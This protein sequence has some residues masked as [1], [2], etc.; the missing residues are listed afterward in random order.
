MA[1]RY[2]DRNQMTFLP[3]SIEEY[4]PEDGPVRAYDAFVEALDFEKLGIQINPKKVGNPNY[5]P[6]AMLKLLVYGYS[7]GV[8]SSRK[9][10]REANYNMS[11]IWLMGGLKPDHKTIAEF[12]RNNKKALKGVLKQCARLCIKLNLIAGNTLFVDGTKIRAN[13]SKKNIWTHNKC[14][15]VLKKA[16]KRIEKILSDCETIDR[17][18]DGCPS[19]VAMEED[20]KNQ[21]VLK[22]RVKN[23][24]NEL[25][26]EDRQAINTTDTDCALMR[27]VQGSHAS[28]NMQ[29][30]VDQKHGLIVNSDVVNKNNDSSQF[31]EQ[32]EQA[33]ETMGKKCDTACADAGYSSVDELEKIDEQEIRVVVPSQKQA[34]KKKKDNPFDK[35]HFMYDRYND[36]YICPE[37]K[38][39]KY[40]YTNKTKKCR[41]YRAGTVCI[42]CQNFGECTKHEP[43]GRGISRLLKVNLQEK[44]EAQY[45]ESADVYAI[46]KQKVELPFGHIKRNLNVGGFLMRGLGGV[47]AE[48]S[49]YASCFNIARMITILGVTGL[50]TALSGL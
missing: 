46:R 42:S 43:R 36:C 1:Y 20:L 50:I 24:L 48:A 37:G 18:E 33:H 32:I 23:I 44:L 12:R 34:L 4:I 40:S 3:Q 39:L 10:E 35:S 22:S 38:T 11:F 14:E 19:L 21:K 6:R 49:L 26:A 13:A 47:K 45:E 2:G 8:R 7:Y 30:T 17:K 41:V 29:S 27:S 16:D 5:D 9:L 31:A 28:Y 15:K 25:E